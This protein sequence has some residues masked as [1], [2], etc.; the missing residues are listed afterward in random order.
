[1]DHQGCWLLTES[2]STSSCMCSLLSFSP[3]AFASSSISV[4]PSASCP[5]PVGEG[6]ESCIHAASRPID[7]ALRLPR[8]A[9]WAASEPCADP[10]CAPTSSL[11]DPGASGGLALLPIKAAKWRLPG[12]ACTVRWA[13]LYKCSTRNAGCVKLWND[14]NVR[15]SACAINGYTCKPAR[16]TKHVTD[17]V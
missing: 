12:G 11:R 13:H 10:S 15:S 14:C 2:W 1:M 9:A 5:P 7:L 8:L 6:Q 4:G 3:P 17:D 16:T